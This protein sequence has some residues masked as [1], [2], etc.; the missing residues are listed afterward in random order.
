MQ[1]RTVA[2]TLR[3]LPR[4]AYVLGATLGALSILSWLVVANANMPMA[5]MLDPSALLLFTAVWGIGMVAMMFPSLIPMVYTITVSAR[6]KLED[7][8]GVGGSQQHAVS[9][10]ASL[11]VLGYV[12]VWTIVGVVFYLVITVLAQA[13]F[14]VV[15]S[16]G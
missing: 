1:V 12:A 11:F 6:K 5:G 4:A 13:G 9:I 15:G 7:D 3:T 14:S 16:L 8:T 10:P 2:A